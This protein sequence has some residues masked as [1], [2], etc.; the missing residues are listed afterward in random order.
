[1][2]AAAHAA[3]GTDV[4][5][6]ERAILRSGTGVVERGKGPTVAGAAKQNARW[7]RRISC[8]GLQDAFLTEALFRAC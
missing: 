5:R 3:T 1:M 2:E 8:F 6:D 7:S 4:A